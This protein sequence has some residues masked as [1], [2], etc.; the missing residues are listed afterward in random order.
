MKKIWMIYTGVCS[1]FATV[2]IY[3]L[4]EMTWGSVFLDMKLGFSTDRIRTVLLLLA[5]LLVYICGFVIVYAVFSK[6]IFKWEIRFLKKNWEFASYKMIN[7]YGG[8]ICVA[9][10]GL[11]LLCVLVFRMDAL[12][13][14]FSNVEKWDFPLTVAHAGGEIEGYTYSNCREAVLENYKKGHRTFEID[15]SV[16]RDLVLV[17]KHDWDMVVQEGVQSGYVPTR[18]EFMSIPIYGEFTPMDL[19][20]LCRLMDEYE[21]I[22]LVTDVKDANAEEMKLA[23][24]ILVE[25]VEDLGKE[26]ILD[27][28]VVQ[29]YN[30]KT[31]EKVEEIYPFHNWIFTLYQCWDGNEEDFPEYARFCYIKGIDTITMWDSYVTPDIIEVARN[32]GIEI[33]VHTVNDAEMAQEYIDMGVAGIY[34]DSVIPGELRR[35]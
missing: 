7:R 5:L 14:E 25:T 26:E 2:F 10:L 4:L 35:N 8:R 30:E 17:A 31:F 22:W 34:T 19:E 12:K 6:M 23:L 9:A 15:F 24:E 28:F 3:V 20:D 11:S 29:I 18:E 1:L 33:Y 21:D 32:Y 16:T 27:R 13:A